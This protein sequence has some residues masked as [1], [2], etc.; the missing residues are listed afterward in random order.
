MVEDHGNEVANVN[1]NVQ[2]NQTNFINLDDLSHSSQG[3]PHVNF[4]NLKSD[5]P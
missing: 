4:V 5:A 2:G 3:N 1:V